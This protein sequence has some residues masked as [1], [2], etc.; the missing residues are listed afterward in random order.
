MYQKEDGCEEKLIEAELIL[1]EVKKIRTDHRRAG[2]R[3]LH[4]MLAP[5]LDTHKIKLGRDALFDLL[6][7]FGL[8]VKPLKRNHCTTN[9]FHRFYKYPN[10]IKEFKPTAPNQLW[11]SDITYIEVQTAAGSKEKFMYLSVITDA[12]S[13]KIVGWYLSEDY[14]AQGPVKAL[15]IALADNKNIEGLIHHSDRGVQ[16]C[17]A[18]YTAIL[19]SKGIQISMTENGDPYENALAERVNGIIKGEYLE[20]RYDD[21]S[22]AETDVKKTVN[23]YN[24]QR[25]HM[26]I[27]MMTP[28]F[29]HRSGTVTKNMWRKVKEKNKEPIIQK[30]ITFTKT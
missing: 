18:E 30:E 11:V 7:E 3:K 25:L 9:S 2:T 26:S 29:I 27:G 14:S 21:Q 5:F 10:L 15:K 4:K 22:M 12:F 20:N 6:G 23:L 16:Y 24:T 28:D 17:S 19:K 1:Q 13:R 8:L